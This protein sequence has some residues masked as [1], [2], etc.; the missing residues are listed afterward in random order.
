MP[1]A[2]LNKYVV[3]NDRSMLRD[4]SEVA[5]YSVLIPNQNSFRDFF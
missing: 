3:H 2:A 4:T 5:R 1:S